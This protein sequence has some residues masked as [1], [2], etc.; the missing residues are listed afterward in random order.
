MTSRVYGGRNLE[1]GARKL[2][3]RRLDEREVAALKRLPELV[4][5]TPGVCGPP[6]DLD[7]ASRSRWRRRSRHQYEGT[8]AVSATRQFRQ[9]MLVA[10]AKDLPLIREGSSDGTN[11]AFP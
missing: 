10:A 7:A 4:R 11:S 5:A 2:R 1:V 9:D 8:P 6:V 3:G